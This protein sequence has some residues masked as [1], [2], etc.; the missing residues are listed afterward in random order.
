VTHACC[1]V[2][3][4]ILHVVLFSACLCVWLL[5][6]DMMKAYLACTLGDAPKPDWLKYGGVCKY[7]A[8]GLLRFAWLYEQSARLL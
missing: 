5:Q 3:S 4:D 2:V 1:D 8:G 6:F 7:L